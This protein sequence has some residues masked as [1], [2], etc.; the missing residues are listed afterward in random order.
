MANY[1]CGDCKAPF[2]S[3]DEAAMCCK[4]D[5][6]ECPL[7]DLPEDAELGQDKAYGYGTVFSGRWEIVHN[8]GTP[9]QPVRVYPLPALVGKAMAHLVESRYEA[10]QLDAKAAV[11]KAL[12]LNS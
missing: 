9:K 1:V 10:G 6:V 3:F 8:H 5:H 2:H 7:S 11:R 12:G 4:A